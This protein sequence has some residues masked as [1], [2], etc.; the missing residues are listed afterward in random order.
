MVDNIKKLKIAVIGSGVSGLVASMILSRKHNVT[1]FEKNNKMGGHVHTH[2]LKSS[3]KIFNVDSGFIVY[4]ERTYPNFIKLLNQ[5]DV[6]TID[7]SMG[8]SYKDQ[9]DFEYSGNSLS[10]LFSKKSNMLNINFY[11]FIYNI[12]RFNRISS[13]DISNIDS[14]ITLDEYLQSKKLSDDVIHKYI[15]PMGAAIWSTNP[16]TMKSMPAKFFI[17]FFMNHGL[18]DIKNRPQWK[19]IKNGSSEYVKKIYKSLKQNN[20]KIKLDFN[21]KK[22]FRTEDKIKI[23]DDNNVHTFDKVVL[24]CH[25]NQA[26]K[27]IQNPTND[28]KNILS[29]INY[30]ENRATIHTDTSVLPN[31]KKAWSSWNYLSTN[32]TEN[33]VLTYNMNILQ[34]LKSDKVFCVT[35]NDPGLI[36]KKKIIKEI[37]YEHPLFTPSCLKSQSKKDL[38]NGKNNTYFAG[39]YWGYG[40]HEDGVNSALDVCKY[41]DMDL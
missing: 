2:K 11:F 38:I 31:R 4:N 15:I 23:K 37:K 13:I 24:A 16:S 26:L 12:L 18:L 41:F 6:E 10:T 36:D 35:I 1:I 20:A 3:E 30:Q 29:S 19:V 14:T 34:N 33:V 8:F 28:E 7:T 32:E 22:V 17:R 39:A 5:L 21:I 9:N 40:F 27:M 25:S